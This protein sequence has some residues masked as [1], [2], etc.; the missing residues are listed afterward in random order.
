MITSL[1]SSLTVFLIC[2]ELYIYIVVRPTTTSKEEKDLR[3]TDIPE[4]VVCADPGLDSDVLEKYGYALTYYRG[5]MD[6][7]NFVGWN[8]RK[9]E[10]NSAHDILEEALVVD[11]HFKTLFNSHVCFQWLRS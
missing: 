5:S 7:E 8:G 10:S 9:N 3:S 4:T 1:C 6:R 2:H 11:H